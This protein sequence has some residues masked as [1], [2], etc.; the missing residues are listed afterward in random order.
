MTPSLLIRAA[1]PADAAAIAAIFT[2]YVES[3]VVTFEVDPPAPNDWL[4]KIRAASG[5]SSRWGA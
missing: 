1:Q 5:V 4:D 3:S 2:V